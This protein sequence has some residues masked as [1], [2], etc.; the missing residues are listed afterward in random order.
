MS[1][2]EARGKLAVEQA[3]PAMLVEGPRWTRG[4]KNTSWACSGWLQDGPGG[5]EMALWACVR[6]PPIMRA[7]NSESTNGRIRRWCQTLLLYHY[8]V[9]AEMGAHDSLVRE[10]EAFSQSDCI[11]RDLTFACCQSSSKTDRCAHCTL[12]QNEHLF[13]IL[14][15][16]ASISE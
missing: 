14:R 7:P 5:L 6:H 3:I 13:C 8:L 9:L 11:W 10:L 16:E 15:I 1:C 2:F 12:S 4:R